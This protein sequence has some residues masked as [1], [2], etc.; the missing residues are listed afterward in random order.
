MLRDSACDSQE[1]IEVDDGATKTFIDGRAAHEISSD[2]A[3]CL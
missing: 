3:L 2:D 1:T